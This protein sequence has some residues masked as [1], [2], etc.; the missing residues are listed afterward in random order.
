[1]VYAMQLGMRGGEDYAEK[2]NLEV[3]NLQ[4]N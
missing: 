2:I 4:A 3:V 1:M